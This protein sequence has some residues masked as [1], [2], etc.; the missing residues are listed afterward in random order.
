MAAPQIV[1]RALSATLS[2]YSR[3]RHHLS[4]ARLIISSDARATGPVKQPVPVA[5]REIASRGAKLSAVPDVTWD[6]LPRNK[7]SSI[8]REMTGNPP[9]SSI[10]QKAA[11]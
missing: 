4:P 1:L 11:L 6:R 9:L 2:R 7:C 10:N 3:R 8:I 5:D